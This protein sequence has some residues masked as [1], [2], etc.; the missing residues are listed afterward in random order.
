MTHIPTSTDN[1]RGILALL[2]SQALFVTSDSLIKM[3]GATLPATQIMALRG[4]IATALAASVLIMTVDRSRWRLA[5]QPMVALRAVLEA[6]SA[7]LFILSLPH[8][9]LAAITVLMQITPLT[10]TLLSA[11]VLG[12]H[13]GW[14]RWSAIITGFIGVLLVAQPGSESF[15]FYSITAIAV[16]LII[17]VRDLITRRL[18]P[19][20]PTAA[21]TL[22]TTLS[23]CVLGF[24][25]MPLQAWQPLGLSAMGLLAASAILVTTANIFI[26][27][28]FRGVDVTVVSPFRY[29]GVLWGLL[30]SYMIWSDTPNLLALAGMLLIVGSGLCTMHRESQRMRRSV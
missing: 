27:R 5:L 4:V 22:S 6:I 20:I 8:L 7:A 28:A 24:A 21:V 18:D 12:A 1:F 23:V 30:L 25:G 15:S 14:R 16:A 17:S 10:I 26:I 29:F 19:Q 11:L 3:A 9:T 13:V 2:L